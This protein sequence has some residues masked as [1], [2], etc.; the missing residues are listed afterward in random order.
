VKREKGDAASRWLSRHETREKAARA[1]ATKKSAR[2]QKMYRRP[3]RH[4]F[5][6]SPAWAKARYAA[7]VK[8][9]GKCGCCGRT[10]QDGVILNVDHI[11]PV[12]L[13]PELALVASNLQVLCGLCN[14]GKGNWDET[15]WQTERRLDIEQ[16][17][18]LRAAGM[19]N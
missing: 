9:N 15:D 19:L 17:A 10:A 16:L 13:Y 4:S 6:R 14:K 11:K 7:L 5:Y 2:P 12:K 3:K 1:K 18:A 8:A